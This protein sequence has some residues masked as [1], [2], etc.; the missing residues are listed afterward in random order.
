[1]PQQFGRHF[2]FG[3]TKEVWRVLWIL[4]L[5]GQLKAA[6]SLLLRKYLLATLILYYSPSLN[7]AHSPVALQHLSPFVIILIIWLF[8]CTAREAIQNLPFCISSPF[9]LNHTKA[10]S[11]NKTW[12]L[13]KY[14]VF[15]WSPLAFLP[16]NSPA[17]FSHRQ[18]GIPTHLLPLNYSPPG[19][20]LSCF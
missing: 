2:S 20:T 4:F 11:P 9:P 5:V 19:G 18:S 7:T 6:F 17:K 13:N 8:H 14:I 12:K 16:R 1:M 3:C 15:R 10:H